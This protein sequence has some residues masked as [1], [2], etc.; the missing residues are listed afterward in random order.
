MYKTLLKAAL[1]ISV[2]GTAN[3]SVVTYTIEGRATLSSVSANLL[4]D[5]EA[6]LR[7][8]VPDGSSFALTFDLELDGADLNPTRTSRISTASSRRRR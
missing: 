8:S 3:A 7:D 6:L 4:P 2:A 5:Y 1:L